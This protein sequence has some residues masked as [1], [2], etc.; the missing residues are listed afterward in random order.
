MGAEGRKGEGTK[1]EISMEEVEV[2]ATAI[3]QDVGEYFKEMYHRVDRNNPVTGWVN[4]VR[5]IMFIEEKS[6]DPFY[7]GPR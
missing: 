5:I 1:G 2:T 7:D 4:G 6:S 3:G